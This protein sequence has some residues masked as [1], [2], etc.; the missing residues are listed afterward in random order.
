MFVLN[1]KP[2]PADNNVLFIAIEIVLGF[3]L[4]TVWLIFYVL[5]AILLLVLLLHV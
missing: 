3:Y 1:V 5:V 4:V 2:V